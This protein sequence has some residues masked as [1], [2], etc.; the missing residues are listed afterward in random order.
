MEIIP[1]SQSLNLKGSILVV[2]IVST[3]NVSQLAI[4][5]MVCTLGLERVGIVDCDYVVPVVGGREGGEGGITTP[6]ELYG[7]AGLNVVFLQQRSPVMKT[8]KGDFV[9]GLKSLV[10]GNEISA[11]FILSGMD[12][13]DRPDAHMNSPTYHLI[14]ALLTN[15]EGKLHPAVHELA[16]HFPPLITTTNQ[17]PGTELPVIP[18]SGVTRKLVSSLSPE[19]PCMGVILEYVLEGDNRADAALLA[20]ALSRSLHKELGMTENER[21]K[22]P[23][24]WQQGLFGTAH[25]QSLFG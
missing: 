9:K 3:G 15:H 5:L 12:L 23:P 4:D 19:F 14:P 11:L 7:K 18:G 1:T 21:W 10:L 8:F 2:P 17:T 24:S 6:L 20:S 16:I 13:S 25:D 22:E